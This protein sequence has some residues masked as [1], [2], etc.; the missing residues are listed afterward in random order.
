MNRYLKKGLIVLITA[1]VLHIVFIISFPYAKLWYISKNWES[2]NMIN[3]AFSRDIP[4]SSLDQMNFLS[5]SRRDDV[6][7][8]CYNL[9]SL[10]N[11]FKLPGQSK[12]H[13][14]D[15][16]AVRDKFINH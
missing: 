1:F 12:Y 5:T 11:N 15:S 6:I 7:S 8:L 2:Q 13:D 14:S 4:F 3:S 9:F 10:L 16:T